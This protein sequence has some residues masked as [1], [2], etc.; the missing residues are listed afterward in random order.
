MENIE[1]SQSSKRKIRVL[2]AKPGLDGH[3]R[4]I[5]VV[6]VALRDAG[7][8]VIYTGLYRTPEEIV[9]MAVQEYVDVIG[10]SLL[11]GSHDAVV[12]EVMKLL[13]KKKSD[14]IMVIVGGIIPPVDIP[15]LKECG[16]KE[17]FTSGTP[18]S[19]I[20]EFIKEHLNT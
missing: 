5:R 9:N 15:F 13:K 7:M 6:A 3:D 18:T 12:P 20:V 8:E 2:L 14:N 10:I 4:G 19:K 11:S 1:K 16:V 17:V